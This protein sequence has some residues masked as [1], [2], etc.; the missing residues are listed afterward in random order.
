MKSSNNAIYRKEAWLALERLFLEGKCKKI[1]VSNYTVRHL[2]ELLSYCTIKPYVNQFELHPRLQQRELVRFCQENAV[3]VVTYSSLG[4]GKLLGNVV[5]KSIATE[6]NKSCA[7]I[8]LRWATQKGYVVLP[9][10]SSKERVLENFMINDFMLEPNHVKLLD[11]LE[12]G[13]HFAWD[14][15]GVS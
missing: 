12:D 14:P 11:E 2:S 15:T 6:T 13:T 9:K 8:L 1:G 5:V 7:Q 10:C 4:Q 3:L